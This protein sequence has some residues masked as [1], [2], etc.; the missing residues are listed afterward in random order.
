LYALVRGIQ[1]ESQAAVGLVYFTC[2]MLV[3]LDNAKCS[4]ALNVKSRFTLLPCAVSA[5]GVAVCV[6]VPHTETLA[7]WHLLN[8]TVLVLM[9]LTVM[10]MSLRGHAYNAS[11]S[12]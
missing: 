5:G 11:Y 4:L 9:A 3:Y 8:E 1:G 12:N 10:P 2:M 7:V 6:C